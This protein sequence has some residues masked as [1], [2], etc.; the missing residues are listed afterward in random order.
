MR[1]VRTTLS[2]WLLSSFLV[3]HADAMG[4]VFQDGQG[5]LQRGYRAGYS[6]GYM[7]G[8]RDSID[9]AGKGFDKHADYRSADRAYSPDHG[10][11]GHYQNGYRQGFETGY[12]TGF[13][14]MAFNSVIPADLSFRKEA[15]E[16]ARVEEE[17][18]VTEVPRSDS[19]AAADADEARRTETVQA[20]DGVLVIKR[21]TELILELEDEVSTLVSQVGDKFKA[22]VVSP[23]DLQGWVVEGHVDKLRRPGRIR[24]RGE[25]LLAFDRIV[26]NEQRWGNVSAI[27]TEVLPVKGDNV[28][29]VD[30]EG[31]VE[32][33]IADRSDAVRVGAT[34]GAG[35]VVG[36]V[37]GGPVGVVVGAGVGAAFGV[38]SLVV[39]K[40]RHV[41]LNR[42]QQMRVRTTY[43]VRIR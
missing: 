39:P 43:E 30:S 9:G 34:S 38:G 24:R 22:K 14:K 8:Y 16:E 36:G 18:V 4:P 33:K 17:P 11:K 6:D 32:G 21:D 41:R 12:E 40:G 26:L 37:V 29:R 20:E 27:M 2:V 3:L 28:R 35:A 10:P 25:M 42:L 19:A 13:A 7:A 23:L 31:N 15:A 5:A 1:N